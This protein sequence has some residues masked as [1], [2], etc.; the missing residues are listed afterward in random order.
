MPPN[1]NCS[2]DDCT[3]ASL[4]GTNITCSRC[5]NPFF[6]DCMF[7]RNE[8]SELI[9]ILGVQNKNSNIS[10]INN[11]LSVLFKCESVFEFVCPNCKNEL[12]YVDLKVKLTNE[13]N[14]LNKK[15]DK[16]KK[17]LKNLARELNNEKGNHTNLIEKCAMLESEIY[18]CREQISNL[19]HNGPSEEE[20]YD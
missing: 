12:S 4:N 8:I 19:G 6:F 9:N 16:Q 17:E 18:A 11:K 3:G 20:K 14:D 7:K 13:I 15:H 1:H 5:Y 2:E 10:Q